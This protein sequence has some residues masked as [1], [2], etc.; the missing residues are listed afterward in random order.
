MRG[1]PSAP[2]PRKAKGA[3]GGG[4]FDFKPAPA[5]VEGGGLSLAGSAVTANS[6]FGLDFSEP[7]AGRS[8]DRK[9]SITTGTTAPGAWTRL[10]GEMELG[11]FS[12]DYPDSC[13]LLAAGP[14]P[15]HEHV[16]AEGPPPG[17]RHL[18]RHKRVAAGPQPSYSR[19][20]MRHPE[21]FC[22]L[23]P[24]HPIHRP[25]RPLEFWEQADILEAHDWWTAL[26][27]LAGGR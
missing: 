9:E 18:M 1:A 16:A 14:L 6:K 5:P 24:D 12:L 20:Q 8:A 2:Q 10:D 17:C 15:A 19:H 23:P 11:A 26:Y 3:R 25:D 22:G 4:Q 27:L 21:R 7:S 13:Y